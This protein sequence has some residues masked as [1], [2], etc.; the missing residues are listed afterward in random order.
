MGD[1][2]LVEVYKKYVRTQQQFLRL[3]IDGQE[4]FSR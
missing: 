2:I 3:D 4:V 1:Q